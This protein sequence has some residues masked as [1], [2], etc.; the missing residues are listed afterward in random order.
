MDEVKIEYKS[1]E[2]ATDE[3]LKLLAEKA[4]ATYETLIKEGN[5]PTLTK[6]VS[7]YNPDLEQSSIKRVK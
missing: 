2:T 6:L 3:L 4:K 1:P 5:S 7:G